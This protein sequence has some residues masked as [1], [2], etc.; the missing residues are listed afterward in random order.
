MATANQDPGDIDTPPTHP[1]TRSLKK[2][3]LNHKKLKRIYDVNHEWKSVSSKM[4]VNIYMA[5]I[6][7]VFLLD[8]HPWYT[9]FKYLT[10]WGWTLVQVYFVFTLYLDLLGRYRGPEGVSEVARAVAQALSELSFAVQVVVTAFFWFCIYPQEPWRNIAW[11]VNMHGVGLMLM[12]FDYLYRFAGFQLRN[13]RFVYGFAAFYTVIHLA[14]VWLSGEP[15][16]PGMDFTNVYSFVVFLS[17]LTTVVATHKIFYLMH[18]WSRLKDE[19]KTIVGISAFFL[20]PR[21]DSIEILMGPDEFNIGDRDVSDNTH[22]NDTS[23]SQ[24]QSAVSS[25]RQSMRSM[26][27]SDLS[28]QSGAFGHHKSKRDLARRLGK[29]TV[30]EV[31]SVNPSA[32][33]RTHARSLQS[34]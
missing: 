20:I 13:L 28:L 6:A 12:I 32:Q 22:G 23:T 5:V 9:Y 3:L 18:N 29:F 8:C 1:S 17:G 31:L 25:P 26:R 16:Y 14:S 15:I 2:A 7:Y 10:I 33:A 11:E 19:W 34:D 21:K 30:K 24:P 27:S 4:L